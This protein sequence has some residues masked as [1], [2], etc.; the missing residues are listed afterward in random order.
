[1]IM[2]LSRW[3]LWENA[4]DEGNEKQKFLFS[5]ALVGFLGV[6]DDIKGFLTVCFGFPVIVAQK[7]LLRM[8]YL[9]CYNLS[10]RSVTLGFR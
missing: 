4:V 5:M 8:Y 2:N 1:M 10:L 9:T 6:R 7:Y 3:I